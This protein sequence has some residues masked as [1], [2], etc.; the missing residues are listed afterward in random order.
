MRTTDGDLTEKIWT[1]HED[2]LWR[3]TIGV[4]IGLQEIVD[5]VLKE[6]LEHVRMDRLDYL[7]NYRFDL[8]RHIIGKSLYASDEI[9]CTQHQFGAL[10]VAAWA[11][12][13]DA[14]TG[15]YVKHP[16]DLDSAWYDDSDD[17]GE[18]GE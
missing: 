5:I 16:D 8:V 14:T 7:D 9:D 1:N 13:G 3:K 18:S 10:E 12:I 2:D 11:A 6:Y 15:T 17:E 4:D